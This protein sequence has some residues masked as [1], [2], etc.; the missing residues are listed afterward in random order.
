MKIIFACILIILLPWYS[1][2]SEAPKAETFILKNG[3]EVVLIKNNKMPV[4]SHMVWYKIGAADELPGKSG[5]AHFLEHLMFKATEKYKS[6]EFSKKIAKIGGNDNAF[7][8]Y[9]Y[10]AYYQNIPK[11]SLQL[12]MELESDRMQNLAFDE[13]EVLKERDVILEE[14]RMR[15]DS[16]PRSLLAEQMKAALFLN[17]PYQRPLIGWYHEMAGLT[18]ADAK[19]WYKHYYN[20]ANA[21]LV[22]SG[23]TSVEELKPLAEKYYG[24]IAAGEKAIRSNFVQ[25]PLHI[26]SRR[27]TLSDSKVTTEELSRYYIAPSRVY[28]KKEYSYALALLSYLLGGCDT[29]LMYQDMVVKKKKAVEVT[30]YYD[31]LSIGPSILALRATPTDGTTL[32]ELEALFEEN[33]SRVIKNGV[34]K[35]DLARAKK[36]TITE[37]IYAREDLRSLANVYGASIALGLG[38]S[39]VENWEKD[40]NAVKVEDIQAAAKFVLDERNSVTGH[41]LPDKT[42]RTVTAPH[43]VGKIYIDNAGKD[44]R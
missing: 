44:L 33:I 10:T 41:L 43:P 23:D 26:A 30:S 17:H 25:E 42:G 22:V 36:A 4:I 21:I 27:V 39:Y 1:S 3:M 13:K 18:V 5:I 38:T 29:S 6:G 8:D 14:R 2:A 37:A 40:I 32:A 28:G 7:T 34:D 12:V 31:D 9:D 19:G 16:S 15:I 35:Q 11:E 24:K 20:P